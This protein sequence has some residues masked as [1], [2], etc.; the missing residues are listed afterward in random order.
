MSPVWCEIRDVGSR[1][2]NTRT[3]YQ[4]SHRR[5]FLF[6]SDAVGIGKMRS[7]F[8]QRTKSSGGANTRPPGQRE[9]G[10]IQDA[11]YGMRDAIIKIT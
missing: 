7:I 10:L 11:G 1:I 4:Y 3:F 9:K 8:F 2:P 5:L 6:G